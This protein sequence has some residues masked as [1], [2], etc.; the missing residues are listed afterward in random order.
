M[1]I[2]VVIGSSKVSFSKIALKSNERDRS[3]IVSACNKLSVSVLARSVKAAP[4]G[5]WPASYIYCMAY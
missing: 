5:F 4:F 2:L 3:R 1:G